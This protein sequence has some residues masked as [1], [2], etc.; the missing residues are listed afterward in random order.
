MK[1]PEVL[2]RDRLL[3]SYKVHKLPC[4]FILPLFLKA[5]ILLGLFHIDLCLIVMHYLKFL[6][7]VKPALLRLK[8]TL[9]GLGVSL[10]ACTALMLAIHSPELRVSLLPGGKEGNINQTWGLAYSDAAA[11]HFEPD[12]FAAEDDSEASAAMFTICH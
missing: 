8:L 10:A 1:P 2:A 4:I 3:G 7:Q 6:M 5:G 9:I 11:R 12:A